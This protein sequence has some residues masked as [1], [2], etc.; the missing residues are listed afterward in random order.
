MKESLDILVLGAAYGLLPSIR[1]GLAGHRVTVVCRE[2]ERKA[3]ADEGARATFHRRDGKEGR[4][5]GLPAARGRAS[6][7]GTL[8]LVGPETSPAGFDLVL[9]AM[10][11]PQ[12]AAPEVAALMAAIADAES[13][14]VTLMN[15]LPPCFLRRLERFDVEALRAAY[16]AWDVWQRLDPDRVTAASPDAQAVRLS[17]DQPHHLTVT[18]ASNFKVAPFERPAD[19]A[20]LEA[21]ASS[22]ARLAPDDPYAPARIVAH[23][24]VAIPLSKWPMLITGNCRCLDADGA[25]VSIAAA[26]RG[27]LEESR[28][29][30]EAVTRIVV[31]AGMAREDVV[32]FASYA[33]AARQLDQPSSLARALASGA[34][35]VE[36]IDLMVLLAAR[37]LGLPSAQIAGVCAGIQQRIDL[38]LRAQGAPARSPC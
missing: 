12:F 33:A 25:I 9:L 27:D 1:L 36:R 30:Y 13:P 29:I 38:N 17:P 5:L 16:R 35:I 15:L 3:L 14:V 21:V 18:L 20:V 23:G 4:T 26:V 37:A 7:P 28:A 2:H 10:G 34:H 6:V 24:S 31:E 19:Q 32:P 11:E 22:L 8:G